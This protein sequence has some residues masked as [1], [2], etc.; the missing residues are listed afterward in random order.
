MPDPDVSN[1]EELLDQMRRAP[2]AA[3]MFG[4]PRAVQ[5]LVGVGCARLFYDWSDRK[6][7]AELTPRGLTL[8]DR[9]VQSNRTLL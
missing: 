3:G 4:F 1:H 8:L 9:Q 2:I 5:Y 6:T 7:K